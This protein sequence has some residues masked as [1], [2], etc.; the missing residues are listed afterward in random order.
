M[1]L[2]IITGLIVATITGSVHAPTTHYQNYQLSNV[3]QARIL[4]DANTFNTQLG[5]PVEYDPAMANRLQPAGA[6]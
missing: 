3:S 2:H 5:T 4:Q 6:P 1:I